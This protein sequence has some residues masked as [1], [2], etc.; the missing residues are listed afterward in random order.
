TALAPIR[1]TPRPTLLPYPTLFRSVTANLNFGAFVES[2]LDV[3]LDFLE[4]AG[5]DQRADF[6]GGVSRVTHL[7]A[8]HPVNQLLGEG[9]C[10]VLLDV[11]AVSADTGLACIAKF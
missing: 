1:R 8:T 2:V 3:A 5:I 9:V 4:S 7:E 10:N 6:G 11:D